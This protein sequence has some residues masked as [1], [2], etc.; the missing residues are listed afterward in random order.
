MEIDPIRM[1]ELLVGL[2]DVN[3]LGVIDEPG[4][5]LVVMVETRGSRPVCPGCGRLADLKDR[6]EV[7][8]FDLGVFGR[9]AKLRWVKRRWR[10]Q[11]VDCGVGSWT[12][13]NDEIALIDRFVTTRAAR[14]MCRQ[15]G[16]HGRTV[17]EV[18]SDLGCDWHTVND[19]VIEWGEALLAVDA[20]RI[21]QVRGLGLDETL[22]NRTG[23]WRTQAWC[24]SIV[25]VSR[26]QLLDLVPG[27]SAAGPTAWLAHR[28]LEWLDGI[29]FGVL[30]LS[31]PYRAT[32][33]TILPDAHQVADPFHLTKLANQRL[34]E[35]R[36]RV[37]NQTLGHRGHR[38]DPLYRARRL[39]TKADERLDDRGRSKLLG[40]LE[41]GDPHGEVRTAWH[42]KEVVRSIYDIDDHTLAVTFV[43]RLATDL[44][45][46]S[47]PPEVNQLGRT[48]ARWATQITNWHRSRL[49]NG[50]TEA[51]NNLVK[52]IKRIG[53][54]F[55][56]FRNYRVRALLYA[57]RP[58]WSLLDTLTPA[59]IR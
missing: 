56:R 27:R 51:I 36:R 8:H 1:C 33:D 7:D 12:E 57:G 23:R 37:Q 35:V 58:N 42:A 24:T 29:E 4:E 20:E 11:H 34:D 39:L 46:E 10:C 28:P 50:P 54:G 53:F 49:S 9:R 32:F 2:G 26:G 22:F 31:G 5:P 44:Q 45:D 6:D 52:R 25:D 18:A 55:R 43:D 47:V 41:A 14:W 3:V 19:T 48:I 38:N 15:V 21:D 16:E 13:T 59:T 30:D 17:D 40:L